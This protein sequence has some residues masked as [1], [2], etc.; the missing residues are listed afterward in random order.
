M[1]APAQCNGGATADAYSGR[2]PTA[3]TPPA[4]F[5]RFVYQTAH[6]LGGP[7]PIPVRLGVQT[8]GQLSP[9]RDN[10]VLVCHYYTGTMHAAGRASPEE[11]PGWW[12]EVIGPGRAIDTGRYFVVC[13]N[14]PA[15]VQ[16]RDP[17][18][19][20]T[21]P[22]TPAPDGQPWDGRF[23]GWTFVDNFE[24]QRGLLEHLGLERWHAVVGPSLGGMQALYWA[25]CAPEQVGRVAV[26]AA[27]PLAGPALKEVFWPLLRG[28][29]ASG[30]VLE[31]LRLISFFGLGSDGV[32]AWFAEES[33]SD[34]LAG[35]SD[36]ASLA[37]ILD[38]GRLVVSH[39]LRRVAPHEA[40]FRRW[41]QT[42][43]RL[44]SANV[45]GDQF[46]PVAEMRAFAAQS[47]AAG[48][49]HTHLEFDSEIGHL[50]CVF[51]P[52]RFAEALR[53]LMDE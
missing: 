42:G 19:V 38:L 27:S 2:V 18:V 41:R 22:D 31:A 4:P 21:G 39:D 1:I 43:L 32:R 52:Q 7:A 6:P 37:H 14:T 44:L 13:M 9:G 30:G 35:R 50:A 10:A 25:A 12:D 20:T 16:A 51:E 47:G 36:T 11:A 3:M 23:P 17:R 53:R 24:L 49:D 28:V 26:I 45:R 40:L 48:V 15:N 34:Y 33:F 5:Q 8:W 46:F 29:A